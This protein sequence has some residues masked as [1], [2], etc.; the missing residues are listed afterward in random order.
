MPDRPAYPLQIFFDGSCSVCAAEM[1]AYRRK[2]HGGRLQFVDISA[3]EFDPSPYG[4]TLEAFMYEMHAI[5]LE[6]HVYRGVEAFAAIWQA[7]PANPMYGLLGGLI[8]LPGVNLLARAAYWSFARLRPFLP[9]TRSTCDS[10]S[11]AIGRD[12]PLP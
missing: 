8:M 3:A 2:E 1:D 6:K 5:D 9:K 10:G 11:C 4:I 7:F 12:K